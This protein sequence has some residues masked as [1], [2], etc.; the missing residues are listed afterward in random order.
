MDRA[1]QFNTL[2][3]AVYGAVESA[4]ADVQS[5]F[6]TTDF[7]ELCC[8]GADSSRFRFRESGNGRQSVGP[9]FGLDVA[10]HA[11]VSLRPKALGGQD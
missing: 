9:G 3:G 4:V 5:A 11:T 7:F 2:L 6:A 1:V 8:N 10:R